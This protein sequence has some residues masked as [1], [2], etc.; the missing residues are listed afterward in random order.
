MSQKLSIRCLPLAEWPAA[1]REAWLEAV[2]STDFLD[3]P[4]P[5]GHLPEEKQR[6]LRSAYG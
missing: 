1:D 2:R 4:N 6:D 3:T 5:F